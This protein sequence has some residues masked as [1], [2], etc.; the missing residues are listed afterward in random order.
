M[1]DMVR[2]QIYIY[3]RQRKLLKRL[4]EQRG[5]SEAEI[6]RNAIDREAASISYDT[7][8]L[9][10]DAWERAHRFMLSLDAGGDAPKQ[11]LQWNRKELYSER[12]DRYNST[13]SPKE[14][15]QQ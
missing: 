3:K 10:Q 6:V 4:S 2:K 5:V 1:S 14:S 13:G 8:M 12:V 9:R 7:H 11:P 15:D